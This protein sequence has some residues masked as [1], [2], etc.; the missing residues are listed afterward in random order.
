MLGE[1]AYQSERLSLPHRELATRRFVL[2]PLLEIEPDFA[3]PD[4]RRAADL[5][6][7]VA[8]QPVRLLEP[9]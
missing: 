9:F 2:E 3:L 7:E 6:V 4:G 8:E 5:I 1:V